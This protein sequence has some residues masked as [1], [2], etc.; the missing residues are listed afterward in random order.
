METRT[1][2][3][4]GATGQQ[5]GNVTHQLLARGHRV[6]AMTRQPSRAVV[7]NLRGEREEIV[8]GDFSRPPEVERAAK[9]FDGAFHTGTPYKTDPRSPTG[10]RCPEA[11]C[12]LSR[13]RA[14]RE[15][16]VSS[17]GAAARAL[18]TACHRYPPSQVATSGLEAASKK[19]NDEIV[20]FRWTIP[21]QRLAC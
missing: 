14:R 3:V 2:F 1:F 21:R 16:P 8:H 19:S 10:S 18:M 17:L 12:S 9:G 5:G 13:V 4:T 15:V 7:E 11:S 20:R 6:R